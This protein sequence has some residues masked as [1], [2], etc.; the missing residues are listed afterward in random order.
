MADPLS[1]AACL[2]DPCL[3]T[4][5]QVNWRLSWSHPQPHPGL[6]TWA[7]PASLCPGS[8]SAWLCHNAVTISLGFHSYHHHNAVNSW[9]TAVLKTHW[10]N[11]WISKGTELNSESSP[12]FRVFL[13]SLHK[14]CFLNFLWLINSK[15]YYSY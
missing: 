8:T 2:L 13:L 5:T 3:F 7:G 10:L 9:H 4:Q 14:Y 1:P 15:C 6:K 11:S 12:N